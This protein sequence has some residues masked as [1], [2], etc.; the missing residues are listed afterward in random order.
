M[1]NYATEAREQYEIYG[2]KQKY[3]EAIYNG[4]IKY[5]RGKDIA[6][7]CTSAFVNLAR[8][9]GINSWING[10]NIFE[11]TGIKSY[12]MNRSY[13]LWPWLAK[14]G[15]YIIQE[16]GRWPSTKYK[17]RDEFYH[18]MVSVIK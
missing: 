14:N 2:N 10:K 6:K 7:R 3:I 15:A 4:I 16:Q 8:V 1:L 13:G 18:T 17:I 12:R 5:S 11:A 9:N